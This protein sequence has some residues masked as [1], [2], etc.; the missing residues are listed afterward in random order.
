MT[1]RLRV[2][3]FG[4]PLAVP[5]REKPHAIWSWR[6]LSRHYRALNPLCELCGS[7]ATEV[8]HRVPVSSGGP[9][10]DADN[11]IALCTPCHDRQH[12]GRR[13]GGGG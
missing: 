6:R 10:L 13:R 7:L 1:D 2:P 12:G 4:R 11:L 9:L 3:A 5:A 8:H